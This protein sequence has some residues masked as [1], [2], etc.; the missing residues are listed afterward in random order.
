MAYSFGPQSSTTLS[1]S[2]LRDNLSPV[3]LETGTNIGQ[4]VLEAVNAGFKKIISIEIEPEFVDLV[5][6]KFINNSDY[7]DVDFKFYLGDSKLVIPEII[8]EIEERI[9]FWLDGHEFYQIPLLDELIAIKN[10]K[11]KDHI[12]IIDDVRMFN[13]PEWNKI[14]HDKVIEL[15]MDINESYK[16]TYHP[17]PHGASDILVAKV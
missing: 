6:K 2:L 16:I 5:N 1:L 10:H 7:S 4:G 11:I 15:I 8:H 13:S 12:I 9:T 3:F 14:G 17:S